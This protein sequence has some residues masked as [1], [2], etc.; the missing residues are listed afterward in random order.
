MIGESAK[1]YR[2]LQS[3]ELDVGRLDS[4]RPETLPNWGSGQDDV[5]VQR[6]G[7]D[8]KPLVNFEATGYNHRMQLERR[9][10]PHSRCG[11]KHREVAS[12]SAGRSRAL[13]MEG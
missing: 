3:S 8:R 1:K 6:A 4:A 2:R 7:G 9:P 12:D 10:E 11:I 13:C 5:R